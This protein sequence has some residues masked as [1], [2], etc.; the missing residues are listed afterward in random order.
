MDLV[1]LENEATE[2]L[3]DENLL[4]VMDEMAARPFVGTDIGKVIAAK[5]N[6][7]HMERNRKNGSN[8]EKW[9]VGLLRDTFSD[10]QVNITCDVG[11]IDAIANNKFLVEIKTRLNRDSILK[12]VGQ[13]TLYN[14][15]L[16]YAYQPVVL[17]TAGDKISDAEIAKWHRILSR[18][19]IQLWFPVS[20][21]GGVTQIG[22][23]E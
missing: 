10:V 19:G 8:N 13:L 18:A 2:H 1:A 3:I 5:E 15:C 16:D 17:L 14:S 6:R 7:A 23:L 4:S 12:A 11:R 21:E 9:L 22:C 20:V